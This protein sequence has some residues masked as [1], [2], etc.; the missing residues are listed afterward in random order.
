MAES[1]Q[2]N[3]VYISL[4]LFFYFSLIMTTPDEFLQ[5]AKEMGLGRIQSTQMQTLANYHEQSTTGLC[6][7]NNLCCLIEQI[8]QLKAEN[9]RL[10][11]HLEI[12]RQLNKFR[13]FLISKENSED[14]KDVL[15][16]KTLSNEEKTSALSPTNSLK[17]K[18][19]KLIEEPKSKFHIFI[20][21]CR[22]HH[23]SKRKLLITA[24]FILTSVKSVD[25]LFIF[26]TRYSLY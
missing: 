4:M 12:D 21:I 2:S 17:L 9:N 11:A 13:Q 20:D 25:I 7:L 1:I 16:S 23:S 15:P 5:F 10:R 18:R 6:V 24:H 8:R 14:K 3:Y 22:L 26:Y 19:S